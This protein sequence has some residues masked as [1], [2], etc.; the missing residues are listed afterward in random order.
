MGILGVDTGLNGALVIW[1]E[2]DL[3]IEDMPIIVSDM[4]VKNKKTGKFKKKK[5]D[6]V[7]ELCNIIGRNLHNIDEAIIEVTQPFLGGNRS[8]PPHHHHKMGLNEGYVIGALIA[9]G[10]PCYEVTPSKW[11]KAL[12]C[13]KDKN[14]ARD[15]ASEIFPAHSEQ[16]KLKKHDG[17]AEASLIAYY[18][19]KLEK[20]KV[21]D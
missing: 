13:P 18:S 19:T 7:R 10:V 16:W 4:T 9:F 20:E 6:N 17:R 15:R 1:T 8:T 5:Q 2:K 3:I 12:E 11:K 21:N 14:A